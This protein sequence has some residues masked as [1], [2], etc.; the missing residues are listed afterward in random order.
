MSMCLCRALSI[1]VLLSLVV[2]QAARMQV[3]LI[4]LLSGQPCQG[5]LIAV[6]EARH[7]CS[8]RQLRP[9][10]DARLAGNE[11]W[12][13]MN[14]GYLLCNNALPFQCITR[15]EWVDPHRVGRAKLV[16][17]QASERTMAFSGR[18]GDCPASRSLVAARLRPPVRCAFGWDGLACSQSKSLLCSGSPASLSSCCICKGGCWLAWPCSAG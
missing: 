7:A 1:F 9:G 12:Q 6:H 14:L 18:A 5:W 8:Q 3:L 10:P 11:S 4:I 13:A 17:H 2:C 16:V 15:W